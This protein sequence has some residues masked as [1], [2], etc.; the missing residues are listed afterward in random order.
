MEKKEIKQ[1]YKRNTNKPIYQYKKISYYFNDSDGNE[2][3]E[4]FSYTINDTKIQ[5]LKE[6]KIKNESKMSKNFKVENKMVSSKSQMNINFVENDMEKSASTSIMPKIPKKK[7]VVVKKKKKKQVNKNAPIYESL[8]EKKDLENDSEKNY[9]NTENLKN[10][11]NTPEKN[12]LLSSY[13]KDNENDISDPQINEDD[14]NILSNSQNLLNMP[15]FFGFELDEKD[16]NNNNSSKN[17]FI[18]D[19]K[20]ENKKETKLKKNKS[21]KKREK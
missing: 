5:A 1:N 12:P 21:Q 14:N 17:N 2:D 18:F 9:N 7:K 19:E 15:D 20:K 16:N 11:E 10:E 13:T 3:E 8:T 4:E 6:Q